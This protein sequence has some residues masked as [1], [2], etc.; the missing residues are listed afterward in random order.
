MFYLKSQVDSV[1]MNVHGD[2]ILVRIRPS[3][4]F[5]KFNAFHLVLEI[6]RMKDDPVWREASAKN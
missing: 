3:V 5:R 2:W 4:P 1:Y 6:K